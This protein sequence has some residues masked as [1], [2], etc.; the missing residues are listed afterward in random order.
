MRVG[1]RCSSSHLLLAGGLAVLVALPAL[2]TIWTRSTSV[3][4]LN[5]G[6]RTPL[7]NATYATREWSV[8]ITGF[9]A[10]EGA[11][12]GDVVSPK[13]LFFYRN[14]DAEAHFVAI[15]VQCQDAAR[16]D[17]SRFAYTATLQPNIKDEASFDIVSKLRADDW[18]ST[19]YVKVTIDFVSSPTG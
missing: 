10:V 15:T 9:E 19:Q 12:S 5:R 17:R 3:V 8:A 13:W 18:R 6:S 11:A 1:A 16:K 14:T 4:K 7:A 2:A